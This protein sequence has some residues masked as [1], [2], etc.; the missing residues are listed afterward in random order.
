[1]NEDY[2]P[3]SSQTVIPGTV[4]SFDIFSKGTEKM[5]LC[6]KSGDNIREETLKNI[7]KQYYRALYT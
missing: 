5:E 4:V 7:R 3:I 2:Y 6:C 1:M